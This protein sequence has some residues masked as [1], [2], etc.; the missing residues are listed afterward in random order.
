MS[1]AFDPMGGL[2]KCRAGL[3]IRGAGARVDDAAPFVVR[4]WLMS[5]AGGSSGSGR[6]VA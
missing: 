2:P 1:N 6:P 4:P 3:E 5:S